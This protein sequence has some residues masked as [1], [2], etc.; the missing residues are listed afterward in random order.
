MI[1]FSMPLLGFMAVEK[2]VAEGLTKPT[3]K[4]LLI[5]FGIVGGICLALLL[6]AGVFSFVKDGEQQMPPWFVNALAQDREGLM[7]GDAFRSLVFISLAFLVL[8]FEMWKKLAPIA[9][10]TFLIVIVLL[11]SAIVDARFLTKDDY[12]RKRENTFFTS[13]EADQEILKDKSY[14]RVFNLDPQNPASIFLEARTSYFHNSI[15]GYHAVKLRRY[16][17]L[18]DSCV[19]EETTQILQDAS[20]GKL[21]FSKYGVINML[22]A[23]YIV[24]GPG[25]DNI[26]PNEGALGNA[27]FVSNVVTVNSPTEEL[28]KV[29]EIDTRTTAVVDASMFKVSDV[30]FDSAADIKLVEHNPN[31]LKYESQSGKNGLAVFSEIYYPKGWIGLVDGKETEIVRANYVL[32]ALSYSSG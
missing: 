1:I 3:K 24:Y 28:N 6:F 2:I 14:Y 20:G 10:Y 13:T 29:C 8:Y 31:Y 18:Y 21:D 11:D 25:R 19:F 12:R 32:R 26:I 4:K 17:D 27:W 22:N 16:Q 23:K 15:G 5:A 9:F 30:S 7:R